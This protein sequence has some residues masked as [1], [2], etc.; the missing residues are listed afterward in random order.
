[1]EH[2]GGPQVYLHVQSKYVVL[3]TALSTKPVSHSRDQMDLA[4]LDQ[5][6][7]HMCQ[8]LARGGMELHRRLFIQ[9]IDAGTALRLRISFYQ[10]ESAQYLAQYL[11][12]ALTY[13]VVLVCRI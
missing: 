9:V 4:P 6:A 1:M 8:P 12:G 5:M 2:G 10:M 13:P 11:A 3:L 7:I